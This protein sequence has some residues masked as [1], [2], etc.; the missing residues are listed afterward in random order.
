[1]KLRAGNGILWEAGVNISSFSWIRIYSI[2][3]FPSEVFYPSDRFLLQE[4][5]VVL[6]KRRFVECLLLSGKSSCCTNSLCVVL[7]FVPKTMSTVLLYPQQAFQFTQLNISYLAT[8]VSGSLLQVK[9][10]ISSFFFLQIGKD[11]N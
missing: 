2:R 4:W 10:L 9:G 7:T 8:D 3:L 1:M 5:L 6:A 11:I